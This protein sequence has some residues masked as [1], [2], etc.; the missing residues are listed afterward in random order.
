M[1]RNKALSVDEKDRQLIV[2][3]PKIE[4]H[5]HLE[6]AFTFE[7]LFHLIEKYGGD[8]TIKTPKD[9]ENKFIFKDFKHFLDLWF[10]KNQ[11]FRE[12]EDFEECAFTTLENLSNQNVIYCEVFYSPWDFTSDKLTLDNITEATLRGIKRAENDFSIRC[13]LIADIVRDYDSKK[14]VDRVKQIVPYK[15]KGVIGIGL[16][17]SEQ[18]YPAGLFKEAFAVAAD[19]GFRL[20][21]HAGEA[22]GPESVWD[23]IRNLKVERIG[24]GVRAIE[25]PKLITYLKKSQIPLEVC[26]ISNLK[27]NIYSSTDKHPIKYFID[28]QLNITI[29]SDDPAMF[30]ATITDEFLHL[31]N[32]IGASLD[33]IRHLTINALKSAFISNEPR[34]GLQH[35]IDLFWEEYTE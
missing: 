10:W 18:K 26:V 8:P 12:A 15:D 28:N 21:A 30:G 25:D 3:M 16:G 7:F 24:H 33:E 5:L 6:G 27:T 32:E 13:N 29:N 34:E 22:A 2:A 17:G 23:A 14:A 1:I 31:Y 35:Q 19:S 20:T 9:L 4:L 11:F